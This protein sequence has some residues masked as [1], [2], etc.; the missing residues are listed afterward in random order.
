MFH[1]HCSIKYRDLRCSNSLSS[2]VPLKFYYWLNVAVCA[3]ICFLI[4]VV[5]IARFSNERSV[6]LGHWVVTV[7]LSILLLVHGSRSVW[8]RVAI[9]LQFNIADDSSAYELERLALL[10]WTGLI[11]FVIYHGV[12]AHDVRVAVISTIGE[13]FAVLLLWSPFVTLVGSGWRKLYVYSDSG[14][15][16]WPRCPKCSI[17]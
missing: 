14:Q 17:G 8:L 12:V 10:S 5:F 11:T 7:V 4:V 13:W 1:F 2:A 6:S 9:G 3:F 16:F 15:V